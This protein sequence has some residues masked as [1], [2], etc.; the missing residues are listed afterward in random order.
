MIDRSV[1]QG[2]ALFGG[3]LPEAL[4]RILP[5]LEEEEYD[6]GTVII[7]EGEHNHKLSLILEGTVRVEKRG[8]PLAPYNSGDI[9]GAMELLEVMES[10]CTLTAESGVRTIS[11]SNRALREVYKTDMKTYAILM[12]NIARDLSR[13]LRR[14]ESHQRVS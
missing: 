4:D 12:M 8:V 9:L 5:L 7:R 6:P 1:L 11:L 3:L 2:Y 10:A 13:R 14:I